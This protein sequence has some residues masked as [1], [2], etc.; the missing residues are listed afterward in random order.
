[1][2]KQYLGSEGQLN[3]EGEATALK[4]FGPH[5]LAVMKRQWGRMSGSAIAHQ[6][7]LTPLGRTRSRVGLYKGM[8]AAGEGGPQAMLAPNSQSSMLD[9]A[10]AADAASDGNITVARI[11]DHDAVVE[12]ALD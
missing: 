8:T 1:M 6:L 4:A 7:T 2:M 9:A 10:L 3:A 12:D 5:Q 11:E